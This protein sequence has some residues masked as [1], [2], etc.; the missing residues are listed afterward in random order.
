M[1]LGSPRLRALVLSD[2]EQAEV[3]GLATRRRTAQGLAERARIV[4]GCSEGGS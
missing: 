3:T 1:E 4:L 2:K